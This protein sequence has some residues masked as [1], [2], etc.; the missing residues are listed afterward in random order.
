MGKESTLTPCTYECIINTCEH[1]KTITE[2]SAGGVND[3]FWKFPNK[4]NIPKKIV[5]IML[6]GMCDVCV[7]N[8]HISFILRAV[9]YGHYIII[10]DTTLLYD[11]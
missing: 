11:D 9:L 4:Y 1:A 10:C 3:R 5:F 7:Y 6:Y 8:I 2:F